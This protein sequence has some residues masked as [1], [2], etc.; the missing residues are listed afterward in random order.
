MNWLVK[1]PGIGEKKAKALINLGV[2]EPKDLKK[3]TIYGDLPL[4]TR[5]SLITNPKPIKRENAKKLIKHLKQLLP[6]FKVA[7]SYRR[8]RK[9]SNDIDVIMLEKDFKQVSHLFEPG[10]KPKS[11]NSIKFYTFARGVEKIG[12]FCKQGNLCVKF[13][14]FITT[15]KKYPYML[16]YCTGSQLFNIRMRGHAKKLGYKLNQSELLDKNNNSISG[17]KTEKA[18]FDFLGYKYRE[19]KDRDWYS[20]RPTNA[21]K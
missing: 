15:P 6:K 10:E 20:S 21:N 3:K 2:K 19:P 18:I 12:T 13:D 14:I 8:K 11:L 5:L 1:V 7:G 4:E 16:L 17:L 9:T